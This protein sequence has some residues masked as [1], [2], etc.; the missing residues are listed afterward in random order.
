[1]RKILVTNAVPMMF[2]PTL[3][4]DDL[5]EAAEWFLRVFGRRGVRWEEKYD[6]STL[7]GDYP[8]E[9]SVFVHL[10]DVVVDVLSPALL[11]LPEGKEN[12]YPDG[13]GL[14]DIAWYTE[15]ARYL[16]RHLANSGVRVRNQEGELVEDGNL[17]ASNVADDMYIF[18]TQPE[19]TGL[20]YEF[21]EMGPQHRQFY[22]R[23]GDPRLNP[24]WTLPAARPD[25]PLGIL[26][27]LH[28]T[29]LTTNPDRAVR[30]YTEVLEGR[31]LRHGTNRAWDADSVFIEFA[32]STLE[33]A[34][35]RA[36]L[37]H[38]VFTGAPTGLDSYVGMT[39][40]VV[41]TDAVARH[42]ARH[43]VPFEP[44][45]GGLSTVQDQTM[46]TTWTFLQTRS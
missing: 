2:H 29:I 27:S 5:A 39:F 45:D 26:R 8:K 31:V 13:Q 18:W 3:V 43:D 10:A 14:V 25:D 4:V 24:M 22:S 7:K 19:D 35:P 42:F 33:F 46:G 44:F 28:H 17:P 6:F 36:G 21:L 38:D 9:Y 37:V 12:L 30:L 1:M 23:V 15:D 32:R 40:E 34:Q 16:A 11:T 20:T 41:D